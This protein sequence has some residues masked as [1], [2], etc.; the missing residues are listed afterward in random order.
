MNMTN[1]VHQ[2]VGDAAEAKVLHILSRLPEPWQFFSSVEWRTLSTNGERVGEADVV[3]FHPHYGVV[4]LEIKAGGVYIKDGQWYYASG[5]VMKVSPLAQAR[6]NRYAF[7]EKLEAQLG[8]QALSEL[9]I[10]HAV[11]FPDLTWKGPLPTEL[12][13][14]AF[15]LDRDSLRDPE[16]ALKQLLLA[17]NPQPVAWRKQAQQVIQE[18]FAPSLSLNVPM[19]YHIE[20]S[21]NALHHATQQQIAVLKML[22]TQHRLLIEGC[23]GSGKTLLALTLAYAHAEQGKRVLLT[24][25][26]K[27][28]AHYLQ[29]QTVKHSNIDVFNFHRLVEDTAGKVGLPYLVPTDPKKL[30]AFFDDSSADLLMAAA[31]QLNDEQ[32]YDTIIVDEAADFLEL[33]WLALEALGAANFS[34]YCFYDLHQS[35]YQDI[36]AWKV[37]FDAPAMYLDQNL[38]NTA[39]IGTFAAEQTNRPMPS[40]F[41]VLDGIAPVIHLSKDFNDM[42][43][44]LRQQLKKLIHHD[45]ILP[46]QIVVLSP[47]RHT[48]TSSTWTEGLRDVTVNIDMASIQA[49]QVRVGTIHGFKGMEADVVIIA[50]LTEQA[51][52][53]PEWLYVGA[54]RAR[55]GLVVLSLSNV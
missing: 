46:E 16:H 22:S 20:Q 38:R 44:Q 28:L 33:W 12:P 6:R 51:Q 18:L 17:A 55:A 49:G 47:Y 7:S 34:W 32:R 14:R 8:R 3:V 27:N 4:V 19:A 54:T 30:K 35:I 2:Q 1:T 42:G 40:K 48:N 13:H 10:T 24:C 41:L 11:C 5:R 50:G 26:N 37:P 21:I 15:L 53:H 31:E 36:K 23:A 9:T 45:G 52:Q 29:D 43:Q 25:Y 39:P